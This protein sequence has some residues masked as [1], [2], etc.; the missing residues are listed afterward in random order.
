MSER[1]FRDEI[2]E[3]KHSNHDTL[4][5]NHHQEQ[6]LLDEMTNVF[7]QAGAIRILGLD[8]ITHQRIDIP[9]VCEKGDVFP[10][11]DDYQSGEV[12]AVDLTDRN[13]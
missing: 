13:P 4:Y 12:E 8:V 9:I 6:A 5:C 1:P 2:A 11:A 3:K 7:N 10:T